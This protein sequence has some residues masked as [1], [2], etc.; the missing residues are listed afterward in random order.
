MGRKMTRTGLDIS[1]DGLCGNRQ[2]YPKFLI[3]RGRTFENQTVNSIAGEE[4]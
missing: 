4:L 2:K 1:A 3:T